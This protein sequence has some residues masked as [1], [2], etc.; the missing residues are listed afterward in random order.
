MLCLSSH[1]TASLAAGPISIFAGAGISWAPPTKL[2]LWDDFNKAL[3]DQLAQNATKLAPAWDPIVREILRRIASE[4]LPTDYLSQIIS[5]RIGARYFSVLKSLDG[6]QPN[7][8]HYW[9]ADVA[10]A[11]QLP[12]IITTNFDTLIE[13][14]LRIKRVP[15]QI[16]SQPE[17]FATFNDH[18]RADP[19]QCHLLKIHGSVLEPEGR[20]VDTLAQRLIGLP[21][22]I[23]VTINW[24]LDHFPIYFIGCS[25]RDLRAGQD[26]FHLQRGELSNRKLFWMT[27]PGTE[28]LPAVT[29]LLNF[30]RDRGATADLLSGLLPDDLPAVPPPRTRFAASPLGMAPI[31]ELPPP[32]G[33]RRELADWG[34]RLGPLDSALLLADF[35][36]HIGAPQ[37]G[38]DALQCVLPKD[39]YQPVG[40]AAPLAMRL[41]ELLVQNGDQPSW[42]RAFALLNQAER[43]SVL[44]DR[45]CTLQITRARIFAGG[46]RFDDAIRVLSAAAA[47]P[48]AQML[49][50][51]VVKAECLRRLGRWP[52]ALMAYERGADDAARCGYPLFE[53]RCLLAASELLGWFGNYPAAEQSVDNADAAFRRV[54]S[55]RDLADV[56]LARARL[57]LQQE[58]YLDAIAQAEHAA[59]TAMLSSNLIAEARARIVWAESLYKAGERAAAAAV[60][61]RASELAAKSGD[62]HARA[63]CQNME[64][65]L[66][67][68]GTSGVHFVPQTPEE[69]GSATPT[70][71]F[72]FYMT[73]A[74][75]YLTAKESQLEQAF[76]W[77]ALAEIEAHRLTPAE[78]IGSR[79]QLCLQFGQLL[80]RGNNPDSAFAYFTRFRALI[81]QF[82]PQD[83]G[84]LVQGIANQADALRRTERFREAAALY[85]EGI[86][87]SERQPTVNPL[88]PQMKFYQAIGL[89]GYGFVEHALEKLAS[90][91]VD[92]EKAAESADTVGAML[93][94]LMRINDVISACYLELDRA[95][96]GHDYIGR[97][98]RLVQILGADKAPGRF[99]AEA[100]VA[101]ARYRVAAGERQQAQALLTEAQT[102]AESPISLEGN[103]EQLAEI[104]C[105]LARNSEPRNL[106]DAQRILRSSIEISERWS[107]PLRAARALRQLAEYL[108]MGG[109]AESADQ[110]LL[111]A[112][113]YFRRFDNQFG[114]GLCWLTRAHW[115]RYAGLTGPAKDL[116]DEA[117]RLFPEHAHP[118][119]VIAASIAADP[120]GILSQ[121]GPAIERWPHLVAQ[122]RGPGRIV[123]LYHGDIRHAAGRY[124]N[125][126]DLIFFFSP[127]ERSEL[128]G[129]AKQVAHLP[130]SNSD[131]GTLLEDIARR[132]AAGGAQNVA[133]MPF[134][135]TDNQPILN[136]INE[137]GL[138]HQLDIYFL[139]GND[140][141]DI[142][143]SSVA[144]IRKQ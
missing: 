87:Q 17:D 73:K 141:R 134:G 120:D 55:M 4:E 113:L 83:V 126:Y 50:I 104:L 99:R 40:V 139:D 92:A 29:L 10:A 142:T 52:E 70:S 82:M 125:P 72:K 128:V 76:E 47:P 16:L 58:K 107:L 71:R 28:P 117:L 101:A 66:A 124:I 53:G 106:Y 143:G 2:P 57:S 56:P 115:A 45:D 121:R 78:G 59:A 8:V 30:Y 93:A 133:A 26:Y 64:F 54:G 7:P 94:F 122:F 27:R 95:D 46:T 123:S 100:L 39:P 62:A 119:A 32:R 136:W 35:S 116:A 88:T 105:L 68:D 19:D 108:F 127:I 89:L 130:H 6:D 97:V 5:H 77:M 3:I 102:V 86:A 80:N 69:V 111:Q 41:A 67:L 112:E 20:L 43:A 81:E 12:F 36:A 14:A 103:D 84:G 1:L 109:E 140:Y 118:Q 135:G 23:G 61:S 85:D 33:F 18:L 98:F 114:L 22:P 79:M 38:I 144:P 11:R 49:E 65:R 131:V 132:C 138:P 129:R 31:G 42:V 21:E 137:S 51:A 9:L 90:A 48:E 37:L 25:G 75:R 96:E 60:A 13:R 15:Y 34:D 24:V 74:W 110:A 44:S 63:E 91:A